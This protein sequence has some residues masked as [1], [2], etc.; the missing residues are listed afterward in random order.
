MTLRALGMLILSTL[1]YAQN[2]SISN[3]GFPDPVVAGDFLTFSY[4]FEVGQV[5]NVLRN[6]SAQLMVGKAENV[7]DIIC[8]QVD[9]EFSSDFSYQAHAATPEG[10]YHVR[11][12][13]SVYN[14]L[15]TL[16]QLGT[17]VSN[18]TFHSKTF[19]MST[20]PPFPCTTPT[21]TPVPPPPG[22]AEWGDTLWL[23]NL[24]SIGTIQVTPYWVDH[25]FIGSDKTPMIMELVQSGTGKSAGSATLNGSIGAFE[26]L[27]VDFFPNLT[28]GAWKAGATGISVQ[29]IAIHPSGPCKFHQQQPPRKLLGAVG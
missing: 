17:F 5:G 15:E 7:A 11:M 1:A 25:S 2:A 6:M 21:W 9:V 20:G 19:I 18:I 12:N 4:L 14:T 16:G 26:F 23:T 29:H 10:N 3:F 13:G 24:S 28:P 27:P 22:G 8:T